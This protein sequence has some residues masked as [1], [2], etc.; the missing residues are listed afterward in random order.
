M[1]GIC[2]V[3][4]IGGTPREVVDPATL[5]RMTDAMT[6]R[7][8]NDRGIQ[9]APGMAFGARRLSIVDVEAGHQPFANET[10]DV[11]GMQNG[12]LYNHEEIRRDLVADGHVLYTRCD[13]EILPHLY[14]RHG[15]RIAEQLR[16]KFAVAVWDGRRRRAVV[17]RDRLG[18]KPLYW[19]RA[20]DRVVFASELKSLLA[21]GLIGT[22]LDYEA[23]DAYLAFGFFSGPRTPLAQVSK[24]LPGHRL[25]ID[26]TGVAVERYWSYPVPE[27]RTGLSLD[28]WGEGLIEQLEDAVRSRLMSDV[29]LG[30]ML[31]GGLDSSVI[32]A[33]MARNMPDPVKT[34]SVGFAEDGPKNELS[35]ARLV[36][37]ALG[38]DHHELE[39]SVTDAQVDL[40]Q[41][42][43]QMDEP[44]ADL[45][46]LGFSALSELAAR[47]VTVALSGQ[48]ADELLGGYAKHQAAAAAA[49]FRR[50]PRPLGALAL[51]GAR[52]GPSRAARIAR[53]LSARGSVERLVAMSSKL[54]DDL[55]ARLLCGPLAALDGGAAHRVVAERLGDVADD[56]LPATLYI[57]GQLALV[58]DMLHYFDRASMAHSL[59]VRVP[60]LDHHMVEYCATIPAEH[61]VRRVTHTKHVLK[62]AARGMIPDRIIDKQKIGFFAG[63]VDRWFAAQAG[64]NIADYLLTPAPRYGE[65]LDRDVVASLVRRHADGSDRRYGS[66]LLAILM[67]EVWMT[68]FLPQATGTRAAP[69]ISTIDA[70]AA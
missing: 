62:E 18:V 24:L 31:S 64:G 3:I 58:D 15:T 34:F 39:L 42:S 65:F 63:S 53:T 45:S 4:Q 26:E 66:L 46:S 56:P 17:A 30:A 1:C 40:A 41:L 69:R 59:E 8:P 27:E 5:D 61:K 12:E 9:Q 29:P 19:A 51:A 67:L 38:T 33:L 55:R 32:V 57:D 11:W 20:G 54:D 52:R 21:S 14:E 47:H 16:G 68:S 25:V 49:A 7:G 37:Q 43:W 60:F 2:G 28:E 50:V 44:L 70:E 13:T 48:G 23:I 22:E 10:G 35:D 36:S 6:H